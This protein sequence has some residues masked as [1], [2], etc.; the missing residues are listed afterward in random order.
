MTCFQALL[1]NQKGDVN[2]SAPLCPSPM[3]EPVLLHGAQEPSAPCD[4]CSSQSCAGWLQ[5]RGAA[6]E[7]GG[8]PSVGSEGKKAAQEGCVLTTF[9]PCLALLCPRCA[10]ESAAGQLLHWLAPGVC[11]TGGGKARVVIVPWGLLAV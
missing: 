8:G 5:L 11:R 1:F 3:W 10:A 2:N 7:A 6:G 4:I 9:G